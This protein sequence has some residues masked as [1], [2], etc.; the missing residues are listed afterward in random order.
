VISKGEILSTLT[1]FQKSKSLGSNGLIVE[2]FL[3]FF[4]LIK[5]DLLKVVLES[6][7]L[8]K[9]LSSLNETFLVL[10]PKK[11]DVV[12]FEDYMPISCCNLI[13]K[14]ISKIIAN[15]LKPILNNIISRNSLVF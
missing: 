3:G 13:Y 2:F 14:L 15:R 7:S 6:Q 9:V 11:Q 4:N 8:S 12:S 5:E 1:S 10:I